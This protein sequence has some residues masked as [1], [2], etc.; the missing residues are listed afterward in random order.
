MIGIRQKL[1]MGFGGMLAVIIAVGGLT[2][3]QIGQ[4]GVAIDV[5]LKENYR[6]VVACQG[7]KESLERIDS[8]LLF[9][10]AGEH[11]QGLRLI[12]AN[13][14]KFRAALASELGN[15]TLPGEGERAQSLRGLF[16]R[17]A[18]SLSGMRPENRPLEARRAD[19][20]SKL[21]PLFLK[22][23]S[24]ADDI[25]L[26]NQSNMDGANNHARQLAET[27]RRR[28]VAA[29]ALAALLAALYGCFSHRWILRPISRLIESTNEIRQGNLDL[30][31][32]ADSRDE[33]GRLSLAF[34]EMA[35]ALRQARK[36]DKLSLMRS[37][38]ATED[39]FHALPDA[40]AVLDPDGRVEVATETAERVF[41][42]KPGVWAERLGY[43]WLPPLLRNAWSGGVAC[44]NET[45]A[46]FQQFVENSERFFQP[47]AVPISSDAADG[48]PT[49]VALIL[50]DVTQLHEQQELKRGVIST[51]SHQL[52]TPLT[53]VRM[54]IHLLLEERIGALNAKQADLLIA[55][56]D[57]SERLAAILGDLLDLN[58]LGSGKAHVTPEPA[59]PRELARDAIE[60]FLAEAK[61][62]GVALTNEVSDALPDVLA[63]R[64]KIL[65]AFANLLSNA[66]RFTCPGGTISV[67]A[68]LESG[69]VAVFVEDTGKGIP[70]ECLNHLFEQFYRVPGQDE[71]SGVG[72]GLAITKEIVMA[73]GGTVGVESEV[74]KGSTFRFTLPLCE[75][76]S[77]AHTA[78]I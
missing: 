50:K 48:E 36:A 9:T 61:D 21:Q 31:V 26:M 1:I 33:I 14:P 54:A 34:N 58:R 65:Q 32:K 40:V 28:M 49:G 18:E 19:Y 24:A 37:R 74:G 77:V 73:H 7:M 15:I 41:G 70:A 72:L 39:V 5:I 53:S 25:L 45:G 8:G 12:D 4:L 30:V 16:E 13:E 38:R 10:L 20:F 52:K 29:I 68:S 59:S 27:A 66:L 2:L 67:R 76:A 63:D 23:K 11:A 42:L 55:A 43:V 47:M 17:Y 71:K 6:S 62:K 69:R 46:V 57:D 78:T 3:S 60:P 35:S 22:I 64:R 56:R 51:V 44:G 75:D